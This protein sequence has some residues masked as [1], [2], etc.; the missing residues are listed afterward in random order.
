MTG[1]VSVPAAVPAALADLRAWLLWR[2]QDNPDRPE[3]PRKVP[4]WLAGG[5]RAGT[6]GNARD[7]ANLV[8]FVEAQ[9]AAAQRGSKWGIG[10]ALLP[11]AGIVALD[12]DAC[13]IDGNV[14]PRVLAL[15]AGT[16]AELSPSGTGVRAF[17][18]GELKNAKSHASVDRF[19][20]EVF[21]SNG[22]VTV[23]GQVLDLCNLVGGEDTIVPLTPEVLDL[24]EAR[25]GL[26]AAPVPQL[27]G[28]QLPAE[29]QGWPLPELARMLAKIPYDQVVG[30]D[31]WFS[32]IAAAHYETAGDPAAIDVL[33]EW[34]GN[35]ATREVLEQK[36]QSFGK[37]EPG[38]AL[39]TGGHIERLAGELSTTVADEF[40]VV[41]QTPKPLKFRFVSAA[42]F[43]AGEPP[44][45]IVKGVLPQ[46]ELAVIY[47]ESG[48]GKS[49]F[50]FDL[51]A[52]VARGIEWRGL[53]VKQGPVGYIAAEGAG[54]YR[55]RL[56]AYAQHHGIDLAEL[57]L[58][59]LGDAPNLLTDDDKVVAEALSQVGGASVIVVDTLA[60][61]TAGA[62]ENAGEDMGKVL[63]H[64]KRLHRAT[65]ALVI[66]IHH[67]GKDASKGARGWSGIRAAV[68]AE[69]EIT[70]LLDQRCARVTKQKD[71]DDGAEFGFQLV[72]VNVGRDTDGAPIESCV[73]EPLDNVAAVRRPPRG[74]K[75]KAFY[76]IAQGLLEVGDSEVPVETLISAVVQATPHDPTAVRDRRTE[77]ARKTLLGLIEQGILCKVG[78]AVC[79]P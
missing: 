26:P 46:A 31:Q 66:L 67:S 24:Y 21:Y 69:I 71:G 41:V 73:V 23:T 63:S 48:S 47:G 49:F 45:W 53:R 6:Q 55:K 20:F 39:A 25:F 10:L 35:T 62:N 14:D 5:R 29:S 40:D 17:M 22:F 76:R 79:F 19:G 43:A 30:Y 75:Q 36:W 32:V 68:D 38:A 60:Q 2:Y 70:R 74:A 18:R 28:V 44:E 8:T 65:G 61:T 1:A 58:W 50:A 56:A 9:A 11:E 13:V 42:E 33:L 72:R 54:G 7:R 77:L 51:V 59:V 16:Y 52:A 64:C 78:D 4:Y 34:A 27:E 37:R 57:P 12:F 15:V 3:K